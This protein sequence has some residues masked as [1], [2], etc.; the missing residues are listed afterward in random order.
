MALT[1]QQFGTTAEGTP[2]EKFVLTNKNGMEV[3][4]INYGCRITSLVV[5]GKTG[6]ANVVLGF[7]SL[8]EYEQDTSSQG[9]F[10]GR[11]ANRIK[12]AAFSINGQTYN[13][14]KNNGENHLHG[15]Y[16]K[17]VFSAEVIGESSVSLTYISPS[18][19]E[20]FPGELWV[21][22]TYTLTEDNQFT[23]DYRAVSTADTY[24]NL[25]N[26][27]YFNLAGAGA[28]TME[29]QLLCLN[30]DTFLEAEADL[31]PTGRIL[32][33]KGGAFDFLSEKPI[34]QDI[35]QNDPQLIAAAGYDHNFII[36]KVKPHALALAA[37]AREPESNRSMKVYTTQPGVQLYT[38]NFLNGS[39]FPARSA[40]CLET[41]H[42]PCSPS[43]PEFPST[44]L[45]KGEK[46]HEV[47]V[48]AFE[49]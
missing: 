13:L 30:C 33:V 43:F 39:P 36:N 17:R 38:G 25:T 46:Y 27:S 42:Y 32:P 21:G 14:S 41:Q 7:G 12:G 44:L 47:T 6:P 3:S 35:G 22:V 5:P 11:F 8:A 18:G 10:V 16:H 24:I 1:R 2:V 31:C 45:G 15:T 48:L 28:Q 34:G 37:I 20:G 23:L 4:F 19:E 29:N 40:F 9:S 49:W 26:H